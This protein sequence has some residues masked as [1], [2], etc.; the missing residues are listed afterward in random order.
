MKKKIKKAGVIG[1]GVMGA[2]I[3]AQLAN[4][5]IE[6][7]LL[8]I[9]P[10]ESGNGTNRE[11]RRFRNSFALKGIERAKKSSPASFYLAENAELITAGN[12]EDDTGLLKDADIVIEAIIE[13][14]SLKRELFKKLEKELRP[15]TI[16]TSNTS[17]ISV[18]DMCDGFSI[19]FREYFAVTHFFNPPRYMN[20]IEIVKGPDTLP[21]VIDRITENFER[22]IG[23]RIV[24]AKDTP[25]FIANRIAVFSSMNNIRVMTELNLSVEEVDELTGTILGFPKS[26]TFRTND[27]VGLDTLVHVAGNVFRNAPDDE[28]RDIFNPPDIVKT[29]MDKKLLGDKSGQGFYKKERGRGGERVIL[30]LD[31]NKMEYREREKVKFDSLDAAVKH[32]DLSEKIRELYYAEDSA[33]IFTFRTRSDEFVY[34]ANRIPEISDDI[35]NLDNALKWGFNREMGPFEMWD[36]VGLE[37]SVS[38]MKKKGY[39][40]PAWISNM[41]EKGYKSF[42]IKENGRR[43]YYDPGSEAY[44]EEIPNPGI[45]LLPSLKER[46]KKVAGN[47]DA[48]LVDIGDGVV[49]LEFHSK[50][51]TI[52]EGIIS[53][54]NESADIVSR[55][56]EGMV[57]SNHADNFSVGA[58]LLLIIGA[59]QTRDWDR[60]DLMAKM[61][62]DTLM[63]LKYLDKPVVAAPSGMTLGGGCE[64]CMASD[65]VRYSAETYM[66]LVETGV[67]LIPAGG[68]T[69]ELLIRNT[70][71]LF[72][73]PPGGI[74]QKQIEMLPF[75][76]RAFETIALAKVS[77]SGPEAVSLGYLRNTDRMTVNRDFLLDD[78]KKTVI[79]MNLEGYAAPGPLV[80]IRVPGRDTLAMLKLAIW[81]LHEQGYATEY[82]V[83][84]A[85]K[86]AYV[87]CGGD[88]FADTRVSEKYLLDLEREAFLSLCGN[89]K[90]QERMQHMLKTGKPL[91]N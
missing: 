84:V 30:S 16:V 68:G 25:N 65:R 62:Q 39:V 76:A 85:E 26:A 2:N 29:M 70:E 61:L 31:F 42:Y 5:G 7:I 51:N 87:M 35:L 89:I 64:I 83:T 40:I 59:A 69:K 33:G 36:A 91:R 27:I 56:F 14:L 63:R 28:K 90:T 20:L 86:I 88:L 22:V 60:I 38:L 21:E 43:S 32:H 15:G 82:D 50:M 66:G 75:V 77:S 6:T 3:A 12:L 54:I 9:I 41:L 37:R 79:A 74:Y 53:M 46:Q 8:D 71:H 48:S 45:I 4:V 57:I 1:A 18:A 52:G 67:G 19:S 81:T 11:E 55:D 80:N 58:N 13:D 78:A 44:L 73:V 72:E 24:M 34:A 10:P 23:K 17:G 47:N 49:C